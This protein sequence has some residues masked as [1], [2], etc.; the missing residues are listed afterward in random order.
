MEVLDRIRSDVAVSKILLIRLTSEGMK[1]VD[2]DENVE[3]YGVQDDAGK[4]VDIFRDGL[5]EHFC[6][7]VWPD[8]KVV[9]ERKIGLK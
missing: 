1:E 5:N 7:M 6:Q 2:T 9:R 8:R 4:N 3:K